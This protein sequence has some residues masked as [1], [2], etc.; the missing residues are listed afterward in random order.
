VTCVSVYLLSALRGSK[1]RRALKRLRGRDFAVLLPL[2]VTLETLAGLQMDSSLKVCKA[3]SRCL[4]RSAG[5]KAFRNKVSR[6]PS[7]LRVP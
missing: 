5:C 6:T 3:A 7:T 1:R 2:G 4:A